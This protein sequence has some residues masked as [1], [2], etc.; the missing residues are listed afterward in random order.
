MMMKTATEFTY[1]HT[2]RKISQ[3]ITRV[4]INFHTEARMHKIQLLLLLLTGKKRSSIECNFE[5]ACSLFA[6]FNFCS[7]RGKM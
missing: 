5:S 3:Y 1:S 6:M 4:L 7:D 2:S